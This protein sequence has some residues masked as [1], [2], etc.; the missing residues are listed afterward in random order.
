MVTWFYLVLTLTNSSSTAA[1]VMPRP[2]TT[3]EQCMAD[4]KATTPAHSITTGKPWSPDGYY[5]CV[6]HTTQR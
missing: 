1:I 5:R 4:G 6:P 3:L 2:Y